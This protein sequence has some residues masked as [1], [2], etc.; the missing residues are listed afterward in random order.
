MHEDRE[1]GL[2]RGRP[3]VGIWS[4]FRIEKIIKIFQLSYNLGWPIDFKN[5]LYDMLI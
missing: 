5:K 1:V 4:M 3:G 2:G